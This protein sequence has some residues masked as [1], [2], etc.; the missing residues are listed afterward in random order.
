MH[1]C[2][3]SGVSGGYG[4][5]MRRHEREEEVPR[6]REEQRES[7]IETWRWLLKFEGEGKLLRL[8]SLN[9]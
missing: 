7:F 6:T 2:G 3:V 4:N 1:D 9:F 8:N 5:G